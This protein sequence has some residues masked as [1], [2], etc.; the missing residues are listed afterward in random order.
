MGLWYKCSIMVSIDPNNMPNKTDVQ[1]IKSW[2]NNWIGHFLAQMQTDD[3][4]VNKKQ[5]T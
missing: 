1:R 3:S 2:L 4:T 5:H